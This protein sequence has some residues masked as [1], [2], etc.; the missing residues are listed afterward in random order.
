MLLH[1]DINTGAGR[2]PVKQRRSRTHAQPLTLSPADPLLRG[3]HH[4]TLAR[5][6]PG[7]G[8]AA[9]E[10]GATPPRATL[11]PADPYLR[12]NHHGTLAENRPGTGRAT[13]EPRA[14]PPRATLSP[15]DPHL[16]GNHH[17][18][19]ALPRSFASPARPHA[20]HARREP[21]PTSISR[22]VS[23][24]NLQNIYIYMYVY[25]CLYIYVPIRP[26]YTGDKEFV[27]G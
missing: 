27:V 23:P 26:H 1:G 11:S 3:N 15:A 24:P 2:E 14:T 6:R 21:K 4:G 20:R 8:R 9:A 10:P 19:L 7:T 22:L 13:A 12:G 16:R 17:G 18:A 5:N 25:I